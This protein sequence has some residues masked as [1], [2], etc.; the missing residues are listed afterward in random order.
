MEGR[1]G[2]EEGQGAS[3]Q[4][5]WACAHSASAPAWPS[6]AAASVLTSGGSFAAS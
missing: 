2:V 5:S 4:A 3:C 6:S 1:E